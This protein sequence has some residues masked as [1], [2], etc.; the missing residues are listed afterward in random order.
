MIAMGVRNAAS[1]TVFVALSPTTVMTGKVT[2]IVLDRV[3]LVASSLAETKAAARTRLAKLV[4]AVVAFAVAAAVGAV[5]FGFV[6]FW[7]L[8]VPIAAIGV[9]LVAGVP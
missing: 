4:P 9:L 2:L 1:R 8:L 3:D 7:C 6:G 5:G